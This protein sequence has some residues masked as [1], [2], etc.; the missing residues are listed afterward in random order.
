MVLSN[1]KL[2]VRTRLPQGRIHADFNKLFQRVNNGLLHLCGLSATTNGSS[3][4]GEMVPALLMMC[5]KLT[6]DGKN[7]GG[8]LVWRSMTADDAANLTVITID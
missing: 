8:V 1:N 6:V 4:G 3:G 5:L 7:N 2:K